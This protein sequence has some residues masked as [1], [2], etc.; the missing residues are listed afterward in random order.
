MGQITCDEH[1]LI[2]QVAVEAIAALLLFL[3]G[4]AL[5]TSSL[6]DVTYRG[7]L[8]DKWAINKNTTADTRAIDDRDARMG[9]MG[10]STRGR[11]LFG[12]R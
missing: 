12:D 9:F 8:E 2:A 6:R 10:L 11:A 1:E 5:A 7:E 4:T 3:P